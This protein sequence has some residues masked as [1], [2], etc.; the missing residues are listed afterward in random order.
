MTTTYTAY[1]DGRQID[2]GDDKDA[3][4]AEG[5]RIGEM[6]LRRGEPATVTVLDDQGKLIYWRTSRRIEGT[7]DKQRWGGRK[8]DDAILQGTEHFDAT[9]MVLLMNLQEVLELEDND[10]ST[11]DIG[12]QCVSWD[13]PCSVSLTESMLLFFGVLDQDDI[14]ESHLE[15]ARAMHPPTPR[16]DIMVTVTVQLK[17]RKP[18]GH[19]MDEILSEMD[20]SFNSTI[21]GTMVLDSEIKD[22]EVHNA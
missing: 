13:G 1:L 15:M 12:R 7:F 11:D 2:E 16:E 5:G 19:S 21:P 20:Y 17:I 22:T 6:H 18:K 3:I 9:E 8:G 14:T 10:D 4:V